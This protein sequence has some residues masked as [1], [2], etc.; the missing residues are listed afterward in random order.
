MLKMTIRLLA[1]VFLGTILIVGLLFTTTL[2]QIYIDPTIAKT[3]DIAIATPDE[4]KLFVSSILLACFILSI[5]ARIAI[6]IIFEMSAP[7][8]TDKKTKE[9]EGN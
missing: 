7:K 1:Q 8:K 3:N 9:G 6:Y 2:V 5:V 4:I